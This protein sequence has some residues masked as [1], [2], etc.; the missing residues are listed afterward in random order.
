MKRREC[1][2]PR[3]GE[4]ATDED[5]AD[6]EMDEDEADDETGHDLPSKRRRVNYPAA[7]RRSN[8]LRIVS[9]YESSDLSDA[10]PSPP[11]S[12]TPSP[13]TTAQTTLPPPDPP[14]PSTLSPPEP[15]LPSPLAAPGTALKAAVDEL[16]L[17]LCHISSTLE[18]VLGYECYDLAKTERFLA[19]AVEFGNGVRSVASNPAVDASHADAL[20]VGWDRVEHYLPH[21][22][23][24]RDP[25]TNDVLRADVAEVKRVVEE[26]AAVVEVQ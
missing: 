3:E 14:S 2:L 22:I 25:Q 5:E 26:I 7:T 24:L 18:D 16:A 9:D 20:A 4:D 8:R 13:I 12:P 17:K 15:P 6:D 10:P 23:R 1:C 21:L 11:A 19:E